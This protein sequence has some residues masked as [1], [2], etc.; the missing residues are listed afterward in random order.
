MKKTVRI[1]ESNLK[2]IINIILQQTDTDIVS[3]SQTN[4][5]KAPSGQLIEVPYGTKILKTLSQTKLNHSWMLPE[6]GGQGNEYTD[7]WIPK[8]WGDA[9]PET[10]DSVYAF[11]TPDNKIYYAGFTNPT[12]N[13]IEKLKISEDE[14]WKKFYSMTPDITTWVFTGYRTRNNEIYN[15]GTFKYTEDEKLEK[16]VSTYYECAPENFRDAVN[17]AISNEKLNKTFVK[18]ALGIIGRES[19]YGKMT[20]EGSSIIPS[21]YAIKS[22]AEYVYNSMDDDNPLKKMINWAATKWKG[23]GGAKW[24]PSMGL[25]QM[26]PD[27]AKK[28]GVDIDDLM[29]AAGSLVAATR[30]LS[31]NYNALSAYYDDNVPSNILKDGK[32]IQNPYSTGNAR[33]DAAIASYNTG[34]QKYSKTFC[35]TN[36]SK[37]LAPCNKETYLPFEKSRPD[38][39]VKV[40]QQDQVKNYFPTY[41]D[42]KLTSTGY[43]R[44]VKSRV[45]GF[46]CI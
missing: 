24:V 34:A 35:T 14:K 23:K 33:L 44:E 12:I 38:F 22:P 8:S 37:Y 42:G 13:K 2:K 17:F 31:D 11:Q 16:Y 21:K 46:N 36:D 26:T 5:I 45:S 30:Y 28:Y 3:N 29:T 4:T 27:I 18:H 10:K 7:A 32:L 15:P 6:R 41:V 20:K 25:A 43:L 1:T 39:V 19:S 9:F 40:N